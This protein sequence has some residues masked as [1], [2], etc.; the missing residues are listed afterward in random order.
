MW[1]MF[2]TYFW[3]WLVGFFFN[4]TSPWDIEEHRLEEESEA[5]PL[6]VLVAGRLLALALIANSWVSW[7]AVVVVQ[8]PFGQSERWMNPG[9]DLTV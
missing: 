6:V 2:K 9:Y 1:Q 4:S 8:D 7:Q 5:D 3:A